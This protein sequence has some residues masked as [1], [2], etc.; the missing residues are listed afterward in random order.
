MKKTAARLCT[1]FLIL[2]FIS[3]RDVFGR[4]IEYVKVIEVSGAAQSLSPVSAS[5]KA[6]RKNTFLKNNTKIR[7]AEQSIADFGF[8]GRLENVA[9]LGEGSTVDFLAVSPIK[10]FLEKGSLSIFSEGNR[11]PGAVKVVTKDM[12]VEVKLGGCVVSVS[13]R[14]TTVKV[15]SDKVEL[16]DF[17]RH[18]SGIKTR[19]VREGFQFICGL[20]H[21][22]GVTERMKY[23]DYTGWQGWIKQLYERK[24]RLV[25]ISIDKI[26]EQNS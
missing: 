6:I 4:S 15:F 7:T 13:D 12:S 24:D 10:I 21:P 3:H 25:E 14:G 2:F 1:L 16:T 26:V 18:K 11:L 23:A 19:T 5:W 8:D 20:S 17:A 9:R 22:E